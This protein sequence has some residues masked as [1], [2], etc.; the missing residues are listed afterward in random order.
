MSMPSP[1]P[2][3]IP[4]MPSVTQIMANKV[5][6]PMMMTTPIDY[7]NDLRLQPKLVLLQV[8]GN[9]S[10]MHTGIAINSHSSK[11]TSYTLL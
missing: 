5:S 9:Y 11:V 6:I 7:T 10:K 1:V 3:P 8:I 2:M 4:I